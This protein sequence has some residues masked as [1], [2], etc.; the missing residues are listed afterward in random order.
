MRETP[1]ITS[2]EPSY[3]ASLTDV[4]PLYSRLGHFSVACLRHFTAIKSKTV[5]VDCAP[6]LASKAR[7]SDLDPCAWSTISLGAQSAIEA[8]VSGD[9][10]VIEDCLQGRT[11]F[12]CL[13]GDEKETSSR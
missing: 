8:T 12:R 2:P 5:V 4:E 13:G 6:I 10:R 1:K 7:G 11:V 9:Q 3:E